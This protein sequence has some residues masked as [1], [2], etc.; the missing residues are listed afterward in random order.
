MTTTIKEL[1]VAE[2]LHAGHHTLRAV[3]KETRIASSSA[4]EILERFVAREQATKRVMPMPK[5]AEYRLAVP[6]DD[7][8]R[9]RDATIDRTLNRQSRPRL[10]AAYL[11]HHFALPMTVTRTLEIGQAAPRR[12]ITQEA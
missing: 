4:R 3:A 10:S 9:D 5:P 2:A 11:C 6:I 12:R 8:R 7:I 1:A